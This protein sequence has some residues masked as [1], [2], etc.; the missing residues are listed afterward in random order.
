VRELCPSAIVC[1]IAFSFSRFGF[2]FGLVLELL[3]LYDGTDK[4]EDFE[5]CNEE[6]FNRTK[7]IE[8]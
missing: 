3:K 2:G 8:F 1:I 6:E 5:S 4:G 7:D